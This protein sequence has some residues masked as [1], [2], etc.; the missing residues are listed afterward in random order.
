MVA[1]TLQRGV[2]AAGAVWSDS[3]RSF[4]P[5][6]SKIRNHLLRQFVSDK[7]ERRESR[8]S[9]HPGDSQQ[10]VHQC[11]DALLMGSRDNLDIHVSARLRAAGRQTASICPSPPTEWKPNLT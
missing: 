9:H 4:L 2:I 3:S 5:E 10:V 11:V 1:E 8:P 7:M 6:S